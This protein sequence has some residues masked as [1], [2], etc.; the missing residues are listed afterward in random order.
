MGTTTCKPNKRKR[1]IL[2]VASLWWASGCQMG[3]VVQLLKGPPQTLMNDLLRRSL[4]KRR[5]M[6]D[7]LSGKG[8]QPSGSCGTFDIVE[9]SLTT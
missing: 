8:S 6:H 3:A 1:P 5:I 9:T 7:N 2:K 4:Q